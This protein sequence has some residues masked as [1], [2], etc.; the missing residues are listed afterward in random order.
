M[1]R[2]W[3]SMSINTGLLAEAAV[4]VFLGVGAVLLA[5]SALAEGLENQVR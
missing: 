1:E 5:V 4:Q 3:Y 2:G